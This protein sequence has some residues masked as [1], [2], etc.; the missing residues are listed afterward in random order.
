M[1]STFE[2]VA[3]SVI[4]YLWIGQTLTAQQCAGC[5]L[6]IVG[7]AVCSYYSRPEQAAAAGE[8]P[9]AEPIPLDREPVPTAPADLRAQL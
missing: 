7:V 8:R 5:L 3:T 1:L 4:A 2:I 9:A 6:V